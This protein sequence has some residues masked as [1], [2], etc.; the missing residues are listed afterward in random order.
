MARLDTPVHGSDTD[1]ADE[2]ALAALAL[3]RAYAAGATMWC[4]APQWPD[5]GRPGD[6][7]LA[8][9][10]SLDDRTADLLARGEAW[11]LTRMWLGAGARPPVGVADHVIWLDDDPASA[12]RSG[13]I[14]LHYHLLWELTHV[15][16]EHPGLLGPD[17]APS[18][19]VCITCSDEGRVAEV[20]R[21]GNGGIVDAVVAGRRETVDASLVDPVVPGDL[22]LVHA[23]VALATLRAET[24]GRQNEPGPGESP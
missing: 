23:G 16:F 17:P 14:V 6:V 1:A 8:I 12:S 19:E 3:A 7:L 5:H 13:D 2:L 18:G 24:S 10:S 9:S 11:G 21:V 22:V 20:S 4:V 15:V